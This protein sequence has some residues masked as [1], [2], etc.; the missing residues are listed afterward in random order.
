LDTAVNERREVLEKPALGKQEAPAEVSSDTAKR[1]MPSTRNTEVAGAAG[2][3]SMHYEKWGTMPETIGKQDA[4][5]MEGMAEEWAR[6]L[7]VVDAGA[8]SSAMAKMLS[9]KGPK[10]D[11]LRRLVHNLRKLPDGEL[12]Y[13]VGL[14]GDQDEKEKIGLATKPQEARNAKVALVALRTL[15]GVG[16]TRDVRKIPRTRVLCP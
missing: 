8:S 7:Q 10:A 3:E 13:E 6:W 5:R 16:E 12:T 15:A 2:E 4:E 1:K 11:A 9:G 14:L